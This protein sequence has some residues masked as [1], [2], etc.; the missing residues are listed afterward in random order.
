ME[1]DTRNLAGSKEILELNQKLATLLGNNFY[2]IS[3]SNNEIIVFI[4][5]KTPTKRLDEVQA[6]FNGMKTR[7]VKS[8]P[9]FPV[10]S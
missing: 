2:G 8:I 9:I 7:I 6:E 1:D 3:L 4:K 5:P 10:I